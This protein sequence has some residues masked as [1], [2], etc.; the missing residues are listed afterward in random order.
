MKFCGNCGAQLEETAKFCPYCGNACDPDTQVQTPAAAEPV[1]PSPTA[2]GYTPYGVSPKTNGMAVAG[3]I[4]GILSLFSWICCL[5][6]ITSILAIVFSAIGLSKIKQT[7]EQGRG[8]ATAGLVLGI[9][10]MLGYVI[11]IVLAFVYNI[12]FYFTPEYYI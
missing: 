3:F 4:L 1:L 7:K 9:L 2:Q 6:T 11:Y 5:G 12:A 10:G 8:L